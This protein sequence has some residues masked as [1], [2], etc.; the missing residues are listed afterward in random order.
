VRDTTIWSF[1][2]F[3]LDLGAW[4]L[5]R[6][7]TPMALE[8]KATEVLALERRISG[9]TRI[10]LFGGLAR[11]AEAA[12]AALPW[13]GRMVSAGVLVADARLRDEPAS[14]VAES[15]TGDRVPNR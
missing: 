11:R 8:P 6:A 10:L 3:E 9:A 14:E 13:P 4:R 2:D 1:G 12:L 7:G 15:T 5:S